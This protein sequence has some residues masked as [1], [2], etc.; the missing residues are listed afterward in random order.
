MTTTLGCRLEHRAKPSAQALV[1]HSAAAYFGEV[2]RRRFQAWWYAPNDDPST[3]ELRFHDVYLAFSPLAIVY[4]AM[5]TPSKNDK[6]FSAFQ[7]DEADQEE[8]SSY[9]AALPEVPEDEF[10][11]PSTRYDTLETIVELLRGLTQQRG[12]TDVF[13]DDDDYDDE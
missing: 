2:A 13:F 9:L 11:L 5:I 8:V 1:A 6:S 12:H 3:W 10:Y 4:A 7:I